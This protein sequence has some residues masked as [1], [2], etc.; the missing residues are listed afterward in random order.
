MSVWYIDRFEYCVFS[1]AVSDVQG[2]CIIELQQVSGSVNEP[3]EDCVLIYLFSIINIA[4]SY[5]HLFK[6]KGA[7]EH[8]NHHTRNNQN[9]AVI[10]YISG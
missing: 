10:T 5:Y 4:D 2:F 8:I 9:T 3:R 7:H 1:L 6:H